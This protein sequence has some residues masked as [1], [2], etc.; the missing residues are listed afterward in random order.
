MSGYTEGI[1][2][3]LCIN[4]IAAMGVSLLTGFTGIFSLGHAAYMALGAYTSAILTVHYGVHWL[5]AILLG[6]GVAVIVAYG[7][8]IPTLRLMGDYFAIASI[9]LGEA[10]RLILENWQSLTRGARGYPGIEPYT[11]LPVA[12]TFFP[13]AVWADETNNLFF[14]QSTYS[15][16]HGLRQRIYPLRSAQAVPPLSFLLKILF[17]SPPPLSPPIIP[18]GRI[19]IMITRTAP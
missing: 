3:L 19:T 8:G 12:L 7:I 5:P 6:G 10:I 15:E 17:S 16:Q 9:G 13:R 1:I 4:A 18:S 2:T 14:V 11:T